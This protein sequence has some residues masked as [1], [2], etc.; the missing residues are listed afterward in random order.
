MGT[1]DL[2]RLDVLVGTWQYRMALA[3][4][5]WRVWRDEDPEFRQRF[6]AELSWDRL[7][8]RGAWETSSDG[9]KWEHD[10]DLDYVRSH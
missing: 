7:S 10:F 3:D 6:V 8:M 9:E 2:A 4:G 5:F 1:P